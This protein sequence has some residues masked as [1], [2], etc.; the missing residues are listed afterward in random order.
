VTLHEPDGYNC[1]PA[2]EQVTNSKARR[3][4]TRWRFADN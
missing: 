3:R 4:P 2:I 1:S